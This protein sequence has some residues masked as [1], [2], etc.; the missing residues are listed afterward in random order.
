MNQFTA[1]FVASSIAFFIPSSEISPLIANPT[2][3][4]ARIRETE[5]GVLAVLHAVVHGNFILQSVLLSHYRLD[6][7]Y[8]V[9]GYHIIFLCE[10]KAD[11]PSN[12]LYILGD[13]E[14]RRYATAC[15]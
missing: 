8:L 10:R 14:R 1:W 13:A 12:S 15:N 11:G 6:L 9:E 4:L 3:T 5:D 2:P 7:L